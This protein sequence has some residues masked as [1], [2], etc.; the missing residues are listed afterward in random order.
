MFLATYNFAEVAV[1]QIDDIID[2]PESKLLIENLNTEV[3]LMMKLKNPNLVTCYGVN[4]DEN[5][6]NIVMEYC[7]GGSLFDLIIRKNFELSNKQKLKILYDLAAGIYHLHKRNPPIIHRDIKSPYMLLKEI[8]NCS[9]CTINVKLS[10]YGLARVI[11]TDA[12]RTS[13]S[14]VGTPSWT[15]PEIIRE[16]KYGLPVDVYAFGIVMWEVFASKIPY[17]DKKLNPMQI[18]LQVSTKKLRPTL[19]EL[20]SDTP[21]DVISLMTRCWDEEPNKRP[22]I[23]EVIEMISKLISIY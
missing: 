12:T 6:I 5:K 20:P 1:K 11:E 13:M 4:F 14:H 15:A 18:I 7:A 3:K 19:S 2:S 9:Q 22:K 16:E 21:Q 10:D 8:I 23:D 17:S